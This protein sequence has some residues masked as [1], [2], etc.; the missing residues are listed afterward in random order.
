MFQIEA[1]DHVALLVQDMQRAVKWYYW[2]FVDKG[3][4]LLREET[5]DPFSQPFQPMHFL[6]P[7]WPLSPAVFLGKIRAEHYSDVQNL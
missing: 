5:G 7:S 6:T 2:Y 4:S 1:L 3:I